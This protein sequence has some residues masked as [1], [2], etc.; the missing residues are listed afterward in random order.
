M[1]LQMERVTTAMTDKNEVKRVN[2]WIHPGNETEEKV[3]AY[4][5]DAK[6]KGRQYMQYI[7]DCV[8]AYEEG[9]VMQ[10]RSADID[11]LAQKIA[12][13]IGSSIEVAQKDKSYD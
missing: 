6:R 12:D 2:L 8:L 1:N 13:R 7:S 9:D 4:I 10:L 11:E 5:I 3:Y